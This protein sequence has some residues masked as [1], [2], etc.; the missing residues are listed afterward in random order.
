M[1]T[2]FWT[3]FNPNI[4]VANTTKKYYNQY[5]YKLVL[6]APGGRLI[7]SRGLLDQELEH[8]RL[9]QK[10]F[11]SGGYW[12]YRNNRDLENA[13]TDL[14]EQLRTIKQDTTIPVKIRIEEPKVQI[15][16][17]YEHELIDIAKNYF[18]PFNTSVEILSGPVDKHAEDILNSGSIIRRVDVGFKYKVILRDGRYD[19]NIKQSIYKYLENLGPENVKI[20]RTNADMLSKPTTFMWNVYFYVNDLSLLSFVNLISP[21]IVSNTHELVVLSNK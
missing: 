10:N 3:R 18:V 2:L 17:K 21:G 4:T 12:G 6:H 7:D 16:S 5:L 11:N 14:L 9:V 15:Y 19:F 8:R 20:S 13:N 1:D